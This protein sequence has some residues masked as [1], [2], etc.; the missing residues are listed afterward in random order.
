MNRQFSLATRAFLFAFIPMVLT[1][2]ASF[3]LVSKAVDVRIKGRLRE[4]LQK[5]EAMLSRREAEYAQRNLKA[6]ATL[7]ENPSLKAGVGLLRENR[8][9]ALQEQVHETLANQL[10]AMGDSLD[11]DLL[12]LEDT[13]ERPVV[14]VVGKARARLPQSQPITFFAPSL[15][16]VDRTLY[17]AVSVPIN[18]G[19]ENLGS[20]VVG[21][22]YSEAGWN[23]FGK[24]ALIQNSKVLLTT[25]AK[26]QV[27]EVEREMYLRC[28]T[29]GECEV[30]VGNE[31]YLALPVRQET[32]RNGLQFVSFQSVDSATREFTDNLASLFPNA[33]GRRVETVVGWHGATL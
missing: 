32:F 3:V 30:Q 31:T 8:T 9:E 17:E 12:L 23:E 5:T 28:A 11:Y 6:L 26:E 14:G 2:I 4:D 21:K 20:L 25:F 18:L 33:P 27:S 15:I 7:T 16:Q 1:L 29:S 24:T 10:K 19:D 22:E 13:L